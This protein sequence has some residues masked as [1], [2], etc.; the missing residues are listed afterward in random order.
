MNIEGANKHYI[1]CSIDDIEQNSQYVSYCPCCAFMAKSCIYSKGGLQDDS[2]YM[3]Y[4]ERDM[5][6]CLYKI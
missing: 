3:Y 4:D 5:Y 1:D 2:L 6:I